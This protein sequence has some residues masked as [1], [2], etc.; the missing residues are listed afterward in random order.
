MNFKTVAILT[1]GGDAPGMNAAIRAVVRSAASKG[2]RPLGVRRGFNGLIY[3][4]VFEMNI[5]SVSDII[6]RGGTILYTAR[7]PEFL[8]DKGLKKAVDNCARMN[9]DAIVVIGGD[10]SMRGAERLCKSGINCIC[11]P[12]TIDNDIACSEYSIGFDTAVNN[13][14]LMIDK[15]RDTAQSH[16]R[17]NIIEVM[18]RR[19]GNIAVHTGM[20]VGATAILI[21]EYKF[22]FQKD[23]IDRINFTQ[24]I[25]K[26]HFIIIIAEGLR[27]TQKINEEIV[28][29]IGIESRVTILGH[30]QRGGSPSAKDRIAASEMGCLAVE[31]LMSGENGKVIVVKNNRIIPIDIYAAL[32]SKKLFDFNFYEKALEISV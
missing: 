1:S 19:C 23:I 32:K 6:E 25:G 11:L 16:D 4:D 2:I 28:R 9:I 27:Q 12:G 10:G 22:N 26:R 7:S 13:A 29:K 17:C 20:A 18:G 30:V 24:S 15:I 3:R 8:T 5:R 14:M 31:L 21:P